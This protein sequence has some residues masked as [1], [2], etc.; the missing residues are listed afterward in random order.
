[1]G[2]EKGESGAPVS[3]PIYMRFAGRWQGERE[4]KEQRTG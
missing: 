2:E 3:A 1:M 4:R